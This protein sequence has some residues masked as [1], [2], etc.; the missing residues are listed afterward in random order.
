M[1]PIQQ[2]GAGDIQSHSPITWEKVGAGGVAALIES[3]PNTQE[4]QHAQHLLNQVWCC[5]SVTLTLERC[6]RRIRSS[7][8]TYNELAA[9]LGY[10]L[11]QE[12]LGIR[13]VDTIVV[14]GFTHHITRAVSP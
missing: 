13:Q 10:S 5:K 9:S 7:K 6:R 8:S 11:A 4:A 12:R 3:L 14:P 2:T 1:L